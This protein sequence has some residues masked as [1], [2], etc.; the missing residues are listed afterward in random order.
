MARYTIPSAPVGGFIQDPGWLGSKFDTY[1]TVSKPRSQRA[2]SN[3]TYQKR[4]PRFEITTI[5]PFFK[6]E[7]HYIPHGYLCCPVRELAIGTRVP[8]DNDPK[9][10]HVSWWVEGLENFERPIGFMLGEDGIKGTYVELGFNFGLSLLLLLDD[11][12]SYGSRE[13]ARIFRRYSRKYVESFA[14]GVY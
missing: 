8:G 3:A 11:V 1:I 12:L 5:P 7:A 6:N 13:P 4:L 9:V 2:C 14:L 10:L